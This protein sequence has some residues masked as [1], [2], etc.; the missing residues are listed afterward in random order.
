MPSEA[1]STCFWGC[2]KRLSASPGARRR[3]RWNPSRHRGHDEHD[4]HDILPLEVGFPVVSGPAGEYPAYEA[5]AVEP[6]GTSVSRLVPYRTS[7]LDTITAWKQASASGPVC[8][9]FLGQVEMR[10]WFDGSV[11]F[12]L[13]GHS[14]RLSLFRVYASMDTV[15]QSALCLV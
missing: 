13:G 12:R 14:T 3:E 5:D 9:C 10:G 15:P 7:K 4:E 1:L 11:G 6:A 8:A 2:D